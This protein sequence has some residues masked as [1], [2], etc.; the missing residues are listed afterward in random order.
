MSCETTNFDKFQGWCNS[1]TAGY[2]HSDD[3]TERML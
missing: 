1:G 2:T 3:Y